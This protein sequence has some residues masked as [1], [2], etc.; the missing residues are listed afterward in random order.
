MT[1]IHIVYISIQP[2]ELIK[3]TFM[4]TRNVGFF[5]TTKHSTLIGWLTLVMTPLL[6]HSSTSLCNNETGSANTQIKMDVNDIFPASAASKYW[7]TKPPSA[8]EVNGQWNNENKHTKKIGE[9]YKILGGG[10][11]WPETGIRT[12]SPQKP[13]LIKKWCWLLLWYSILARN[14]Y[15]TLKTAEC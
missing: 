12:E 15:K 13:D 10:D 6:S 2:Q 9:L 3:V 8:S 7:T 5:C 4:E 14:E 11:N 1:I